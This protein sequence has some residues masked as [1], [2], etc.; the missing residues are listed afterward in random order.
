VDRHRGASL[1]QIARD[2]VRVGGVLVDR[3][4][5]AKAALAR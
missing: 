5:L 3:N 1:V 4:A 2:D